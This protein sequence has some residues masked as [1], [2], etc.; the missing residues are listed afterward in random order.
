MKT[1]AQI[2]R[3]D[4]KA[5]KHIW[6]NYKQTPEHAKN[7]RLRELQADNFRIEGRL[8]NVSKNNGTKRATQSKRG[9]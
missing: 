4:R 1:M 8:D 7:A 6:K 9:F 5:M 2:A 3:E